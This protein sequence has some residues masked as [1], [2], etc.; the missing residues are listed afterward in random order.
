MTVTVGLLLLAVGALAATGRLH[1]FS[2][3]LLALQ[4]TYW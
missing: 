1:V 4:V 2:S 3:S